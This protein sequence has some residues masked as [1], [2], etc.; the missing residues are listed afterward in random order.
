MPS[1]IAHGAAAYLL[2][3]AVRR[4]NPPHQPLSPSQQT[5]NPRPFHVWL[6]AELGLFGGIVLLSLLPD[7]DVL[8]GI[9]ANDL[10][11]F[12]NNRSHS[13]F[14]GALIAPLVGG[15]MWALQRSNFRRLTT[16]AF[17]AY[18]L[19]LVMDYFTVGRGVMLWWPFSADR[20]TSPMPL[21]HGV[22][23][24]EGWWSANHGWT[25]LNELGWTALVLIA[26]HCRPPERHSR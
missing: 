18:S 9:L 16:I 13:F 4:S 23:W 25:L 10:G 14:L 7:L 19:H 15:A 17:V 1:P 3:R 6:L 8:P 11:R 20:L 12:H 5:S 22:R 26:V 24:S 21:F 2:Y